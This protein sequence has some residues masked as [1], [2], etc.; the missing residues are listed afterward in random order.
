MKI[1]FLNTWNGKVRDGL[2]RF[3]IEQSSETDVFCFEEAY[4]EVRR[5]AQ[6]LLP[7]HEEVSAH[8]HIVHDDDWSLATCVR[9]GISLLRSE[10]ILNSE[11][12]LGLGLSVQ[13]RCGTKI[14]YVLNFHGL[15]MTRRDNKLDNPA[16]LK[17]SIAVIDFLKEKTG[18]KII[19]GDFNDLPETESIR[20]FSENGYRDLIKEFHIATTRNHIALDK[21]PRHKEYFS[22][23]AFVSPDVVLKNFSVPNI[24]VSDHLPLILELDI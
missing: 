1:I 3:L 15:A 23:Y 4:D 8:K 10:I 17:Q 9:R 18:P 19:G 5:L 16:R 20:M 7:E 24:E 22:D 12:G 14:F 21:Y 2:T 6:K 11:K 13:L